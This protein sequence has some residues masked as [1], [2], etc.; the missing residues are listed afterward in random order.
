MTS[1]AGK[2]MQSQVWTEILESLSKSVPEV[3]SLA[4]GVSSKNS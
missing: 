2:K 3:K 1:E 4:R